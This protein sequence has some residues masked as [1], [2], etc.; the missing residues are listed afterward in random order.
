MESAIICTVF[1]FFILLAYQFGLRNGQRI[2]NGE[3]IK[4][5]SITNPIKA[6]NQYKN[7]KE[8]KLQKKIDTINLE[9]IENYDGSSFGQKDFE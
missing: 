9:N 6:I 4:D 1:G 7:E 8:T 2:S 5:F 3:E